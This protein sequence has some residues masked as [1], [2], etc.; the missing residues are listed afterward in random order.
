MECCKSQS[1]AAQSYLRYSVCN[2]QTFRKCHHDSTFNPDIKLT[3]AWEECCHHA[4]SRKALKATLCWAVLWSIERP[5]QWIWKGILIHETVEILES[6]ILLQ[7]SSFDTVK[8]HR[9][10]SACKG[11]QKCLPHDNL[12]HPGAKLRVPAIWWASLP[13]YA[14]LAIIWVKE[15]LAITWSVSRSYDAWWE[16]LIYGSMQLPSASFKQ[17]FN[18]VSLGPRLTRI[19]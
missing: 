13:L 8:W 1:R 10:V 4:I 9:K 19:N 7:G 2:F 17:H 18:N 6:Q 3:I 11:V 15:Q 5:H 12:C 14:Q 16:S